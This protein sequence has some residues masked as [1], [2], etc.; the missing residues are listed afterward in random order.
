MHIGQQSCRPLKLPPLSLFT[1]HSTN[2]GDGMIFPDGCGLFQQNNEPWLVGSGMISGAQQGVLGFYSAS[3]FS[4]SQTNQASVGCSVKT[5]V[6]HDSPQDLKDLPKRQSQRQIPQHNLRVV[7]HA[8]MEQGIKREINTRYK[9]II[10]TLHN[11]L[12]M[13]ANKLALMRPDFQDVVCLLWAT[14]D[15]LLYEIRSN[16]VII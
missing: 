6:I 8:S 10:K 12:E 5:S 4:T 13:Q 2:I 16:T 1:T 3:K 9:N 11:I 7:V 14:F 15:L